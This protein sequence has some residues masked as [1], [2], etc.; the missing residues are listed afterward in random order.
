MSL[1]SVPGQLAVGFL[2]VQFDHGIPSQ[3]SRL[4]KLAAVLRQNL[5]DAALIGVCEIEGQVNGYRL[6]EQL[7]LQSVWVPN[8]RPN[9]YLGVMSAHPIGAHAVQLDSDG[10]FNACVAT[11][12][13]TVVAMVHLPYQP[14]GG[15]PRRRRQISTLLQDERFAAAEN[16]IIMGDM[17]HCAWLPFRRHYFA[18]FG[19]SSVFNQLALRHYPTV[20]TP[21]TRQY[22]RRHER[23]AMKLTRHPGFSVDDIYVRGRLQALGV[24][25]FTAPSDHL[26]LHAELQPASQP[27]T[28]AQAA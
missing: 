4:D 20:A 21:E 24:T 13:D 3:T 5:S 7:G 2:N 19:F 15:G 14:F 8:D 12:D 18:R 25:S 28:V 6:A 26:G 1:E 27:T 17:N 11:V 22:L 9:E 16:A 23:V 10:K